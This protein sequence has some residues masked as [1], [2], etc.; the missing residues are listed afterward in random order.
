[1][2]IPGKNVLC[3]GVEASIVITVLQLCSTVRAC[4]VSHMHLLSCKGTT[5]QSHALAQVPLT[6]LEHCGNYASLNS[7]AQKC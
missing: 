2:T 4:P 6:A 1:M 5:K 3:D 7:V